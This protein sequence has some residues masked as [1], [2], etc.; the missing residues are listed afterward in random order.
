MV[1]RSE[2]QLYFDV[3][4]WTEAFSLLGAQRTVELFSMEKTPL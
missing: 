1:E 3:V 4:V 2:Q